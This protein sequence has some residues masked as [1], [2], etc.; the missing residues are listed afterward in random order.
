MGP[1]VRGDAPPHAPEFLMA[2]AAGIIPAAL[3]NEGLPHALRS[4]VSSEAGSKAAPPLAENAG[5]P[6]RA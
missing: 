4:I 2:A 6:A 3:T 1:D 5:T